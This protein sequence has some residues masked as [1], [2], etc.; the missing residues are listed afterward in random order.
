[1]ELSFWK[2]HGIGNDF[3]CVNESDVA[4][5][6]R[7]Q[8][9]PYVCDR[10]FGIGSDGIMLVS[11]GADG[12]FTVSMYNPDGTRSGMC[13]NGVRCITRFLFLTRQVTAGT[14]QVSLV[15]D[16]RR[17]RC[18]TED[19]G[20]HVSVDMGVV[21]FDPP[22]VPCDSPA[23]L[24]Q[25]P[26]S[27]SRGLLPDLQG[28]DFKISAASVGNPHAIIV[29]PDVAAVPL[30]ILGPQ[31]ECHSLFPQKANVE[32]VQ[33]LSP[34]RIRIRVWERNLG[35]TLACGSGACASVAALASQ[36]LCHPNCVA[37][38]P[39]GELRISWDP[40]TG[41]VRMTG[42]AKEVFYGKVRV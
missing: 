32:F 3:I 26:F 35:V 9:I 2:I 23:P 27:I 33:V 4:N 7:S 29:V 22:L 30:E 16:G 18:E 11:P 41:H 14:K 21:H 12:V 13:G 6:D 31:I 24:R 36:G 5:C 28:A 34:D 42:P 40:D 37:A 17:L 1:M 39:G 15:F 38:L 8:L 19:E 25:T 20:A 10:R